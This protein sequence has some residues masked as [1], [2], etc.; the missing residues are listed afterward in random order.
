[1][2]PAT[3]G[4]VD[5]RAEV[6]GHELRGQAAISRTA[7]IAR[8]S[9]V[10][11]DAAPPAEALAAIAVADQIVIGPGSLYTSVLAA[12][13]VEDLRQAIA[14]AGERGAQR[15]YVNNL[16]EE[17]PETVGHNVA[18]HLE[19]L[20][21]HGVE[22]DVVLVDTASMPVGDLE[23]FET[24]GARLPQIVERHLAAPNLLVHDPRLLGE[25][26]AELAE[27]SDGSVRGAAGLVS[28]GSDI[29]S[30]VQA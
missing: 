14:A 1:M 29:G 16:R 15:V 12:C 19:A 17:N 28:N 20:R 22:P 7:R 10:P 27:L 3:T 6:E 4:P 2:L 13:A 30:R 9:L 23:K 26:L 25:A 8:V 18:R 21:A 11:S 24:S 5:L